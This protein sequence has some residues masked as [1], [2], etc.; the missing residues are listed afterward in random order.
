MS[1][2]RQLVDV[3]LDGTAEYAHFN[4][5]GELEGLEWTD[6]V[7]SIIENNKILSN[8]GSKGYGETREWRHIAAIP[9]SLVRQWEMEIG[10]PPDFL[11]T[12][13]GFSTLLKKIK[14]PDYSLVRVDK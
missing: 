8:D 4:C 13:E 5:D 2:L 1:Y 11:L 3:G 14:D 9:R 10:V 12:K 7:T 6:D